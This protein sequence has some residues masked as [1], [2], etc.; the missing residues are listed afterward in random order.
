MPTSEQAAI[1]RAHARQIQQAE[2]DVARARRQWQMVDPDHQL[3]KADLESRYEA[4]LERL[5]KLR[6]DVQ[7]PGAAV[8]R[9]TDVDAEELVR[10]S[11]N[12]P[13][14]WHA[15]TTSNEDRKRLLRIVLSAV[16]VKE[17]NRDAVDLELV[18]VGGLRSPIHVLTRARH[19]SHAP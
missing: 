7:Q 4:A 18:W 15:E 2:D 14:L 3:V 13:K 5:Q 19:G 9:V 12:I 16:I 8:A 17:I 6:L 1:Q 10:L 11:S